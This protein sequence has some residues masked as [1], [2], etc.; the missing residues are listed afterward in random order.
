MWFLKDLVAAIE[1]NLIQSIEKRG[2]IMVRAFIQN[3]IIWKN[4]VTVNP[5]NSKEN[6]LIDCSGLLK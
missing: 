4:P 5:E 2:I 3:G 1:Q 6:N